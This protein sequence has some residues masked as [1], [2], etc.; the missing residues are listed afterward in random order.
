MLCSLLAAIAVASSPAQAKTKLRPAWTSSYQVFVGGTLGEL[1][2][3]SYLSSRDPKSIFSWDLDLLDAHRGNQLRQQ[4]FDMTRDYEM[5][6]HSGLVNITQEGDQIKRMSSFGKGM[7]DE[8][9]N[10]KITATQVKVERRATKF[11]ERNE[12]VKTML[13][14]AAVI[15]GVYIGKPVKIRITEETRMAVRADVRGQTGGLELHS[16]VGFGGFEYRPN[17]ASRDIASP[18][19]VNFGE[20]MNLGRAVDFSQEKYQFTVMRE[21]P[22]LKVNSSVLYGSSSN[23]VVSTL[24]KSIF[25]HIT[26]AV[27]QVYWLNPSDDNH[28]SEGKFRVRYDINF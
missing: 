27:D 18:S 5:R 4:Y 20:S 19:A 24:S 28:V 9:Q 10:R 8:I 22:V 23:A 14:P 3:A 15:V 7:W 17:A 1:P 26:V 25:N 13:A 21:L 11:I 16:P 2:N 6:R 12:T